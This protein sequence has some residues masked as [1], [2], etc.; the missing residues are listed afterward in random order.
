MKKDHQY[1]NR[2]IS[3]LIMFF[4]SSPFLFD[5]IISYSPK[6]HLPH[7][8]TCWIKVSKPVTKLVYSSIKKESTFWVAL[9][10]R[11]RGELHL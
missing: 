9:I 2:A 3:K 11:T 7:P 5:V 1:C 4:L 6:S 10:T 8:Y